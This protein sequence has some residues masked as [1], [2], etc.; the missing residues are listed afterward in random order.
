M[1][2]SKNNI[3]YYININLLDDWLMI[4]YDDDIDDDDDYFGKQLVLPHFVTLYS[5]HWAWVNVGW[6][7]MIF[8]C[9]C[10]IHYFL[11]MFS[12]KQYTFV[13]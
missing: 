11:F 2:L 8:L 10:C 13:M 12:T 4:N 9:I 7:N 5:L 1:M 6:C 3:I